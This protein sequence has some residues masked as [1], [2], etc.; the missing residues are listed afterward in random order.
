M[1]EENEKKPVAPL[2]IKHPTNKTFA[3]VLDGVT[4]TTILIIFVSVAL[5]YLTNISIDLDMSWKDFG[6]EAVILYIFTVAINLLARSVAK[7][8]GRE[9]AQHS[10]AAAKVKALESEIIE[11]GLRGRERLYCRSWEEQEL[12]DAREKVLSSAG[13]DTKQ[14]ECLYVKFSKKEL[15]GKKAEFGLTDFQLKVICRAKRIRRLKYDEK[16]LSANLKEGRRVSPTNE[17][18][19]ERY[20][21]VHTVKY[22]ITA[23]AGVCISASLALDIIANPSFGTVVMCIIKIITILISAVAG[24]LGGYKLTAEL[25]TEELLR[26]ATEQKNFIKW[27]ESEN[28]SLDKETQAV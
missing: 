17:I 6:Y 8:R 27:C 24:M 15:Q 22:L 19:A 18:N 16:Y 5:L 2:I 28:I 13:I 12:H 9:T 20:E 14:F 25:E 23:F 4:L 10:E 21:R 7:R 26:K 3:R 11:K 1:I